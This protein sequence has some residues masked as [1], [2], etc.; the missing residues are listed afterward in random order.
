MPESKIKSAKPCGH[1]NAPVAGCAICRIFEEKIATKQ[2][3]MK[4]CETMEGFA[5]NLNYKKKL[6]I[7]SDTSFSQPPLGNVINLTADVQNY[8]ARI[9]KFNDDLPGNW[10]TFPAVRDAYK[11]KFQDICRTRTDS[12]PDHMQGRG[13][14]TCSGGTK[15]FACVYA[16]IA[17]LRRVGCNLPIEIWYLGRSEFDENMTTII[18]SLDQV[19]CIDAVAFAETLPK[20][21]RILHGWEL[22][23]FSILNSSFEEVLFLDADCIPVN[24]PEYLFDHPSYKETG[25]IFWPDIPPNDRKEWLPSVVWENCG[26][27]YRNEVDFETGQ[28]LINKEKCWHP[29]KVTCWMN[30]HSDYYYKFVFGDKSTFHLAWR[31]CGDDYS[32]PRACDWRYPALLQHDLDGRLLFLH[33]CRGKELLYS[34]TRINSLPEANRLQAVCRELKT[35]WDGKI[36]DFFDQTPPEY[37]IAESLAGS[38]S[39]RRKIN[40]ESARELKL[41]PNGD[42]GVGGAKC[43][44][45]WSVRIKDGSVTLVIIGEAHKGTEIGMMFL[46]QDQTGVWRGSWETHEKCE[47]ELTPRITPE[48][49]YQN[50]P[51]ERNEH[52]SIC[53]NK[54]YDLPAGFKPTDIIIDFTAGIGCFSHVAL[55]KGASKVVCVEPDF[56]KYLVLKNNLKKYGKRVYFKKESPTHLASLLTEL[57]TASIRLVKIDVEDDTL[58]KLGLLLREQCIDAITGKFRFSNQVTMKEFEKLVADYALN[59]TY[60]NKTDTSWAGVF[61]LTR[62]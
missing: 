41:L 21:P 13:I 35:M 37:E 30:E 32:M 59:L 28:M 38:Y 58:S 5:C 52:L 4:S 62:K 3:K 10:A 15:F 8:L 31:G 36:Y 44:K 22:K 39:Y 50:A 2:L 16:Q 49:N 25:A 56:R 7:G 60:N 42:I 47:V 17:T 23:P 6:E 48:F 40:N 11:Y 9:D 19:K 24:N 27:A 14:V 43:E 51:D 53:D 61:N 18:E 54:L 33:C 45:K 20:Y 34:A 29:L 1:D 12:K 57:N 46:T 55:C 26:M